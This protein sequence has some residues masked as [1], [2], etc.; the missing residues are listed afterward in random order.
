MEK[1]I[2]VWNHQPD[3]NL[4]TFAAPQAERWIVQPLSESLGHDICHSVHIIHIAILLS[5]ANLGVP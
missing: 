2:I 1:K 4:A 5:T 3:E